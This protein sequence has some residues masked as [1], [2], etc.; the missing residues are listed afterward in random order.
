MKPWSWPILCSLCL[1]LAASSAPSQAADLRGFGTIHESPLPAGRGMKFSCDS[2]AHA[3]LLI[4]KLARDM[5][6]SATVPPKWITVRIAVRAVPVLVRPGLGA[7][8]VLAQGGDAY[9]FTAPPAAGQGEDGL[10]SAFAPAASLVPGAQLYDANYAYPVYLDKWSNKGLGTWYSPYAP[11]NDDPP[12]LKDILN[13]HFQYMKENRLTVH[14]SG[15]GDF[16]ESEHFID[17]YQRPYHIARWHDWDPDIARLDPFDL[18]Q[19]GSVFTG[20]SDYYTGI[21]YGGDR[22]QQ[23]RDWDYQSFLSQH[24]NNP[25]LVDW[26]EPHGEI[27]PVNYLFYNDYGPK[28]RAHFVK[29]LQTDKKYTLASLGQAWHHDPQ[30][31]R[32]WNQV[33]IPYDYALY[34]F[35]KNSVFADRTWRL[36]TADVPASLAAGYQRPQF[37]D[38][39]WPALQM[40]GGELGSLMTA[41]RKRFWYRGTVTVSAAYLAAHKGPLYLAVASLAPGHGQSDPDHVWFNGTDL[42]AVS[43]AGG[44][45]VSGSKDVSGLVHAGVNHIAYSPVGWSIPGGFFLATKPMEFYPF[46]DS[47][48]N[49][50]YVDWHDYVSNNALE[51]ER[52]TIQTIRAA[53]PNRSIKIMGVGDKG[54]FV[55]LMADYG[56]FPHNTGD[57]AF[58]G[59]WDRRLGYPYGVRA[60]AESSGSMTDP[61]TFNRWLG[62][63]TFEN[64]NVFDNFIDIQAMMYTPAAPLWKANFPYL[65]LANRYTMK[66]PEIGMLWSSPNNQLAPGG[67]SGIPYIWDLGRGDLQPLGYS[68]AYFDEFSLRRRL[69][70]GY[71]VLWDCGTYVMS[72]DTVADIRHYVEQGGTYVAIA[73]TG[74]HTLTERDAWPIESLTGFHVKEVRPMGG[75]VTILP[76]QPLFTKLAGQKFA[77]TGRCIDYSGYNFADKCIALEPVA[78]GTQA[79][80][81]YEDGSVAVGMRKVGK[82]RVIVLASPFWRDSY[83]RAGTWWP[84]AAQET[85][86]QDLLTGVGVSPD[87]PSEA[88]TPVWRDRYVANNGTEEYLILFNPGD[89]SAQT[90]TADWNASFPISQVFDPKTGQ[91]VPAKIDGRAARVSVTLAPL[92]TKILATQSSRPPADTVQDWYADLAATWKPSLPGRTVSR[93]DVPYYYAPFTSATGKVVDTASVTPERL[94]ALSTNPQSE[95]G[96]DPKLD[97]ARTSYLEMTP[98]PTQSVLYRTTVSVPASWHPGDIY[99]L[100]MKTIGDFAGVVYL[101]GKQVATARDIGLAREEGVDVASAINFHGPNVLVVAADRNGAA[102]SPDLWRQPA[103]AATL[104]LAG[105]WTVK[106]DEDHAPVAGRLP[107]SLTGLLVT[108]TVVV[109]ASWSRSHVFLRLTWEYGGNPGH[110][111]V[112]DKVLFYETQTPGYMDITPWIKFGRPNRFLFQPPYSTSSW[113]PGTVTIKTLQLEQVPHP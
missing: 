10:A 103:P 11:F 39:Q 37:D 27:G 55:P 77:N 99:R 22:L 100:R 88:P 20:Y 1:L 82:G 14:L 33:P 72:K 2:P 21:S 73:E 107:G 79:I 78:P 97:L 93:P 25:L 104:S 4:H 18:V 87:V 45:L 49:A 5:A 61:H 80:A 95:D 74:R 113:Q 54:L 44:W 105:D 94:A 111:G 70:D 109:P 69:A 36:H 59:P 23:Y 24:V 86:V 9:C 58:F 91:P 65:H 56:A 83:D 110:I 92:E 71:K 101:N 108:R 76:D 13:P 68:Y 84:S 90:F 63:F 31:F 102:G 3:A 89:T 35:D 12:G 19:P 7:Y 60:S 52:H 67:R 85:F 16:R 53:D 40:P 41:V 51:E 15:S 17:K 47:G 75:T 8:L 48:L 64:L 81:R 98:A 28:N 43:A 96:W 34:G 42:G 29:W 57:E 32:S 66:K 26:D 38:A 50:R 30:A 6:A 62:W 46:A 106:P 112:N